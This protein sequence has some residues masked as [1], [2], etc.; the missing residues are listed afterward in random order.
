MINHEKPD[1]SIFWCR[2]CQCHGDFVVNKKSASDSQGTSA[3]EIKCCKVC[4]AE[5]GEP[6]ELKEELIVSA[7]LVGGI[8]LFLDVLILAPRYNQ[9]AITNPTFVFVITFASSSL[10][11]LLLF[12][13]RIGDMSCYLK[14]KKWAKDRAWE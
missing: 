2:K 14:W 4:N 6:K 12:A 13:P 10:F 3:W 7:I 5:G 1:P 8:I 9:R 11:A